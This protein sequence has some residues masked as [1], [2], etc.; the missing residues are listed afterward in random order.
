M[1]VFHS[2]QKLATTSFVVVPLSHINKTPLTPVQALALHSGPKNNEYLDQSFQYLEK[3]LHISDR[4]YKENM[5][6]K[7]TL[8]AGSELNEWIDS[9]TA[10]LY[11][12]N[13]YCIVDE[14][15]LSQCPKVQQC[16]AT[17]WSST[18]PDPKADVSDLIERMKTR[19]RR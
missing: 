3:R 7:N 19:Q 5:A 11:S 10:Q 1:Q 16:S 15:L 4:P 6:A 12:L 9:L 14:S 8:K 17:K 18:L 2:W 13:E